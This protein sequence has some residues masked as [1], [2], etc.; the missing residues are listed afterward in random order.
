MDLYSGSVVTS[1]TDICDN[2]ILNPSKFILWFFNFFIVILWGWFSAH[3]AD[4]IGCLASKNVSVLCV[5][6]LHICYLISSALDTRV[7]NLSL[8]LLHIFLLIKYTFTQE[9]VRSMLLNETQGCFLNEV[10][11][12]EPT[13]QGRAAPHS[14]HLHMYIKVEL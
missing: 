12:C 10:G 3:V 14:S 13:Q 1:N 6:V 8:R 5:C 9:V 2:L 11:P 7:P 4:R